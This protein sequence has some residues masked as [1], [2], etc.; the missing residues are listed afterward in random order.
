MKPVQLLALLLLSGCGQA[1]AR[2]ERAAP[3]PYR[4]PMTLPTANLDGAQTAIADSIEHQIRLPR[5]AGPLSS[6]ARYYAWQRDEAG[7][8]TVVASYMVGSEWQAGRYWTYENRLPTLVDGGCA[9]VTFSYNAA[10][11]RLRDVAC[12][13][14]ID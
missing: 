6:Y 7:S 9:R 10:T 14:A 3:R 12:N 8:R 1:P 4:P 2:N 13:G 5:G 11:Q